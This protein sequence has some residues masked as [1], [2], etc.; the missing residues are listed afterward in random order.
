MAP[1]D[2]TRR[3]SASGQGNLDG[4]DLLVGRPEGAVED[5]PAAEPADVPPATPTPQPAESSPQPD[6]HD[7]V[8]AEI[9]KT[10]RAT[11]AR[12]GALRSTRSSR[13]A[14]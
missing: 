4:R 7:S 3:S 5:R 6:V 9:L 12:I 1:G 14:N 2:E 8:I 11:A 13:S 10:V